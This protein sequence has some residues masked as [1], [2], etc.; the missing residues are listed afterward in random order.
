MKPHNVM[1]SAGS[2]MPAKSSEAEDAESR[3]QRAL[4]KFRGF[5]TSSSDGNNKVGAEL[6]L[7]QLGVVANGVAQAPAKVDLA[8]KC[9]TAGE[10]RK[11]SSSL[12][13]NRS[14]T[15]L[16]LGYNQ[17]KDAGA[18]AVASALD[19]HPTL[20]TLDLGFNNIGDE[21]AAAL[22]SSLSSN[23]TLQTLYL[24]GNRLGPVGTRALCRALQA[25]RS[26]TTLH[27]TGNQIGPEGAEA[28]AA[29]LE[30]QAG[31][32]RS[33][34]LQRLYVG[35][36]SI[37][38]QGCLALARGLSSNNRLLEL[39]L[40]DNSVGDHGAQA[41]GLALATQRQIQVLELAFNMLTHAG[42]EALVN[43]LW[44][45]PA[46][47]ILHL[48]NNR[49]GDRGAQLVA[50]C[51]PST[52]LSSLDL[53]FNGIGTVGVRAIVN[54]LLGCPNLLALTLSGNVLDMEGAKALAFGLHHNST[55]R[56]IYLD[57]TGIAIAGERHIAAGLVG[58]KN[59]SLTRFTGF[60][61]G[62]AIIALGCSV[63]PQLEALTNDQVLVYLRRPWDLSAGGSVGVTPLEVREGTLTPHKGTSIESKAGILS[64]LEPRQRC[65]SVPGQRSPLTITNT[66]EMLMSSENAT[67][68]HRR[69]SE[70]EPTPFL[71]GVVSG[72]HL[73]ALQAI[74]KL[75]YSA[76]DLWELHQYFFS[77]P[78]IKD[79]AGPVAIDNALKD[80]L[81][82]A[83]IMEGDDSLG[84]RVLRDTSGTGENQSKQEAQA[85][86]G[87]PSSQEF[88]VFYHRQALLLLKKGALN[89]PTTPENGMTGP[90]L[91][92]AWVKM[93]D[94]DHPSKRLCSAIVKMRIAYFPNILERVNR[95]KSEQNQEGMLTMLRQLKYLETLAVQKM[96]SSGEEDTEIPNQKCNILSEIE[97]VILE[98][99]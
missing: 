10:A 12:A 46:M 20:T 80:H 48:G 27:L 58:N 25:N 7:R 85:L 69:R 31:S 70:L 77:P 13:L 8:H 82:Q 3:R 86:Q 61:L 21:G 88:D 87:D 45:H 84:T 52:M 92:R 19:H 93:E 95:L 33:T 16:K 99:L 17:L 4:D 43:G 53:G 35:G 90:D 60:Q 75:P 55:L 94:A 78:P 62:V 57:H 6:L 40:S 71:G 36:G 63:P 32:R 97:A 41:L 15:C 11:L 26:L 47:R 64:S 42:V 18:A 2:N 72:N 34:T 83:D 54:A 91:A 76:S 49:I 79:A 67:H 14:V 9:L 24:S 51:L 5:S 66:P 65:S 23:A 81:G 1:Q 22:G 39:Y 68:C 38:P 98:M 44:G 28:L 37:G 73:E 29:T 74:P 89:S 96:S 30:S 59:L 56:Q 50:A